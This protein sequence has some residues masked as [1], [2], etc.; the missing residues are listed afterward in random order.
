MLGGSVGTV[1]VIGGGLPGANGVLEIGFLGLTCFGGIGKLAVWGFGPCVVSSV[2][3]NKQLTII[4]LSLGTAGTDLKRSALLVA[5]GIPTPMFGVTFVLGA[6]EMVKDTV[7]P[8]LAA[9][10][11]LGL[12]LGMPPRVFVNPGI[13]GVTGF[14]IPTIRMNYRLLL[15]TVKKKVL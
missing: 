15:K 3:G 4:T 13:F 1:I 2:A 9:F 7:S 8:G 5:V 6:G 11:G 14:E 10:V 12:P